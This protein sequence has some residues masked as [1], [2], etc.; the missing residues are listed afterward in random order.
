MPGPL[1]LGEIASRLGGRLVGG[2]GALIEQVG[3]L[4]HAGPREIAFFS[5]PRYRAELAATRA[6]AVIVAPAAAQQTKLPRI[7][8]DNPYAYFARVAQLL[9]PAPMPVAGVHAS[10][11]VQSDPLTCAAHDLVH[12]VDVALTARQ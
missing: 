11:Q 2:A 10:A 8:S 4:E 3:S 12:H 9:N 6:G 7:V 5:G 1:T